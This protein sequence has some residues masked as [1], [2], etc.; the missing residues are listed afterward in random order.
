MIREIL[1][2]QDSA[3]V[4]SAAAQ[5]FVSEVAHLLSRKDEV[6]VSITGGSVGILT[7]VKIGEQAAAKDI[8]WK[9]VHIWW[10]DERF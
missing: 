2:Q 4:A 7:L 3:A 5:A 1:K 10:G 6:H 9:R 8:D